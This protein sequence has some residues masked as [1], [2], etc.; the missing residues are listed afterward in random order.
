MSD[1]NGGG[2]E[3]RSGRTDK[4]HVDRLLQQ[5]DVLRQALLALEGEKAR[6]EARLQGVPPLLEEVDRLRSALSAVESDKRSLEQ[7]AAGLREELDRRA[8]E[9][10]RLQRELGNALGISQRLLAQYTEAEQH[11]N[12]LA[13]LYVTASRLHATCS[14]EEV[15][16]AIREVLAFFV[17]CEQ[18][19]VFELDEEGEYLRLVAA[20]GVDRELYWRIPV[21]RG[22]I[23]RAALSGEVYVHAEVEAAEREGRADED[24]LTACVPLRLEGRVFGAI[25]LF[26]LLPAKDEKLTPADRELLNLLGTHAATALYCTGL[27]ERLHRDPQETEA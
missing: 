7:H 3:R 17:G 19:A 16:R 13:H 10:D 24:V 1:E 20:W 6:V 26:R 15:L 21:G 12:N 14:R 5:N 9:H 23:G 18:A 22:P 2:R 27:H 11:N 8:V 25:A 4:E